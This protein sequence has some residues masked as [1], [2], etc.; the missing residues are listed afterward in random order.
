MENNKI[1]FSIFDEM[2]HK[3][4]MRW[5]SIE[6]DIEGNTFFLHHLNNYVN[7]YPIHDLMVDKTPDEF[8]YLFSQCTVK[9]L[10]QVKEELLV[11]LN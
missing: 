7:N 3:E 8:I 6:C 10:K 5:Q 2:I 1:N 11:C 9:D 4:P